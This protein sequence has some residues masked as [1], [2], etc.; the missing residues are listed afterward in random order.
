MSR[1]GRGR[2]TEDAPRTCFQVNLARMSTQ[3]KNMQHGI[4]HELSSMHE[5]K[6]ENYRAEETG[7]AALERTRK[8]K[9]SDSRRRP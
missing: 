8:A 6:F 5:S 2:A 4:A 7:S 3:L 9:R 1:G